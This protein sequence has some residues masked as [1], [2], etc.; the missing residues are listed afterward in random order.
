MTAIEDVANAVMPK[1]YTYGW[2]GVAF[3]EQK[4]GTSSMIV[5]VFG[6]ILVFLILAA[7][8]ESW[9]LPAVILMAVPF[10]LI[11]SLLATWIRGLDNDVYF[12]VGLLVMVG[13]AAKNAILIVEF[14]VE[15][16]RKP[17]TTLA[18]AAVARR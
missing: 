3:E 7:Q 14:A 5:F 15:L 16:A 2:S 4:S 6:V 10:G 18:Q 8:Y 17:N 11:G 1:D 12:Q 9:A 13:L